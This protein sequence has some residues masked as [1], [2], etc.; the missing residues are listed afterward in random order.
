MTPGAIIPSLREILIHLLAELEYS[1]DACV[2]PLWVVLEY[3]LTASNN[4]NNRA[5]RLITAQVFTTL[6]SATDHLIKL[7][8]HSPPSPKS[9]TPTL[10]SRHTV[11]SVRLLGSIAGKGF[12]LFV[13]EIPPLFI[14][15]LQDLYAGR[16]K[17]EAT[18]RA[19]SQVCA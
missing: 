12:V 18:L 13:R 14:S 11:E 19:F 4:N 7:Y 3:E 10:L 5:R 17:K 6:L 15:T 2:W 16:K 1:T 9:E 8:A